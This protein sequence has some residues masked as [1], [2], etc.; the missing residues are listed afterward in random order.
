[1]DDELNILPSISAKINEIIVKEG[2]VL[3]DK[4]SLELDKLKESL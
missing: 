2:N 3:D 4:M 1:M